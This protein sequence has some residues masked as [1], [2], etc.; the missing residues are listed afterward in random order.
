MKIK[1]LI[2]GLIFWTI[3]VNAQW[4]VYD[5]TVHTQQI[6]DQVE[7]LA[8]YVE[9]INNQVEQIQRL[10][11]QLQE[12]QQYN[13][14][15]GD[16]AQILNITGV[17]GLVRDL[18]KTPVGKTITDL[19]RIVDGVEALTYDANGLYEK[20]GRTFTTPSGEEIERTVTDY[21]VF[22][23]VN[24]AT[25]NYTNVTADVLQRRKALKD[26]I[27]ATTQKLQ[28]ATTASE[29]QKLSGVLV[30]LNSALAATDKEV[31]QALALSLVQDIENRNDL[32]KQ[33]K[34][35]REEQQA[36]MLET[37]GNYRKTFHLNT[38]PPLFPEAK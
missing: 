24:K 19:E 25:A 13:K 37:F 10:N 38:A 5:P 11:S 2:I 35:R 33:A 26:E 14:A 16:P 20:I 8:K 32:E 6:L 7:D 29:V 27:A 9:M 17:G 15:F 3:R 18:Q 22:E 23:A 28:S 21:K 1:L 36:E 4:V 34:A 31:D 30:G 12:L